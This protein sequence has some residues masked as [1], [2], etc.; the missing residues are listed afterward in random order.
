MRDVELRLEG[1]DGIEV[2]IEDIVASGDFMGC[3]EEECGPDDPCCNSCSTEIGF[4]TERGFYAFDSLAGMA[5]GCNGD[6][7]NPYR[8]CIFGTPGQRIR[9]RAVVHVG[10]TSTVLQ[11]LTWC[12]PSD[13]PRL[14][15]AT[16]AWQAPGGVAGTGP[17]AIATGDGLLRICGNVE[18]FEAG[19]TP[20]NAP[21][22]AL[23]L[24]PSATDELFERW[25]A[26]PLADLPHEGIPA[27]CYGLV[28]VRR[29][30]ECEFEALSYNRATALEPEMD[31]V[32]QWFDAVTR[33]LG[34]RRSPSDYCRF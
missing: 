2:W 5:Y 29:C 27:D 23:T 22:F 34:A 21:D 11:P 31:G 13:A 6:N 17:A 19:T 28:S 30:A 10:D 20:A 4:R 25:D 24:P 32:W 12:E 8:E 9:V 33:A 1:L 3:T 14:G 16:L 26:T 7:C 18:G 15:E